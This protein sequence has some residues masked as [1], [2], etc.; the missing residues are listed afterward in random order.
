MYLNIEMEIKG[1]KNEKKGE[2]YTSVYFGGSGTVYI[3][4]NTN[5]Y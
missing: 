1:G 3:L 5:Y 2:K 4:V